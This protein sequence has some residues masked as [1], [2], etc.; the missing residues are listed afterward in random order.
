MTP[1]GSGPKADLVA[2]MIA[3]GWPA[4]SHWACEVPAGALSARSWVS[5]RAPAARDATARRMPLHALLRC[6]DLVL[7]EIEAAFR[8]VAP[9]SS[10]S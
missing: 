10:P 5:R 1:T 7:L 9:P 8:F 4:R 2:A 6:T 3:I